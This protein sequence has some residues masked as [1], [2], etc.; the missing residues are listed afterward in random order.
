MMG[1]EPGYN[2]ICHGFFLSTCNIDEFKQHKMKDQY[3]KGMRR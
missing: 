3:G 2:W 1:K